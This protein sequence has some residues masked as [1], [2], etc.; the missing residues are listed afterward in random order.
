MIAE[1]ARRTYGRPEVLPSVNA[2]LDLRLTP[3]E[4]RRAADAMA[5]LYRRHRGDSR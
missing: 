1:P 2:Q 4:K 5:D 3:A